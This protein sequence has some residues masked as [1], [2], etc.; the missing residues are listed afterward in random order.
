MLTGM[1][2]VVL[3]WSVAETSIGSV[4]MLES[5]PTGHK[6]DPPVFDPATAQLQQCK[7]CDAGEEC[8]DSECTTC[9][10]CQPGQST[11][12]SISQQLSSHAQS[13][14][15]L[16]KLSTSHPES[17]CV[18]WRGALTCWVPGF[19]KDAIS[20]NACTACPANSYNPQANTATC[21]R[22]PYHVF[23][24]TDRAFRRYQHGGNDISFC[25]ACPEN[26]GTKEKTQQTE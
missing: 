21:L 19:Y 12:R 5:C 16:P 25:T 2:V 6:M 13:V 4:F 15:R 1:M 14:N 23:S 20:S 7:M 10:L 11:T 17:G 26:S 24:G 3:V 22:A 18:V 8:T 9:S